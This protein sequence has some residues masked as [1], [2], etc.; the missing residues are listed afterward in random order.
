MDFEPE[1]GFE[2]KKGRRKNSYKRREYEA[3]AVKPQFNPVYEIFTTPESYSSTGQMR[4]VFLVVISYSPDYF[5]QQ[6]L[7][8][9][10]PNAYLVYYEPSAYTSGKSSVQLINILN[11]R[12]NHW[13]SRILVIASDAFSMAVTFLIIPGESFCVCQQLDILR[14]VRLHYW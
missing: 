2:T 10:I 6:A 1:F 3:V 8:N 4:N 11:D 12:G 14:I 5:L 9:V 7:P 13:I